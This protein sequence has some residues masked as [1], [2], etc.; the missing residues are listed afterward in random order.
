MPRKVTLDG[1]VPS[2]QGLRL[3]RRE[4][5]RWKYVLVRSNRYLNNV[6]EQDHRAIKGRCRPMMGSSPCGDSGRTRTG[7]QD[8]QAP[9]CVRAWTVDRMVAQEAAGCDVGVVGPLRQGNRECT[10]SRS[11][12]WHCMFL[13]VAESSG[14]P[15]AQARRDFSGW[16]STPSVLRYG[17]QARVKSGDGVPVPLFDPVE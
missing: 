17:I 4:D 10:R 9:V 11:G 5:H 2:H 3:L 15:A 12:G 16:K 1:H 6:V 13:I 7:S 8:T 14:L